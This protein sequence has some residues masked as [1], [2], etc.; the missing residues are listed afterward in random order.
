MTSK[1]PKACRTPCRYPG[2]KSRAIKYLFDQ[3]SV[4]VPVTILNQPLLLAWQDQQ[5]YLEVHQPLLDDDRNWFDLFPSMLSAELEDLPNGS[6][7]VAEGRVA[8]VVQAAAGIPLPLLTDTPAPEQAVAD[9]TLVFNLVE[10][11]EIVEESMAQALT[12]Q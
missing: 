9:A 8:E 6:A 10:V 7:S 2:G 5:L 3:T 4:G 11:P 1:L 12:D